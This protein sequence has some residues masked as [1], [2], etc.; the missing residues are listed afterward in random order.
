MSFPSWNFLGIYPILHPS[1]R[2]SY[3]QDRQLMYSNEV[4]N[5]E[6]R[7]QSLAVLLSFS[8]I[9]QPTHF[10][11]SP[12]TILISV[13]LLRNPSNVVELRQSLGFILAWSLHKITGQASFRYARPEPKDLLFN[14]AAVNLSFSF[15]TPSISS[16][17]LF[18]SPRYSVSNLKG[19]EICDL[20]F[21]WIALS[22]VLHSLSS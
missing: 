6:L 4:P 10:L 22:S 13:F 21:Q 19:F 20:W 11:T 14:D 1:Y 7:F 12:V 15:R 18:M 8:R 5:A 2:L 9:L 16:A 3:L 17:S